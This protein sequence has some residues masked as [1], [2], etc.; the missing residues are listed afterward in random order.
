M[1]DTQRTTATNFLSTKGMLKEILDLRF[2]VSSL[3]EPL[4]S[5]GS[6]ERE[7]AKNATLGIGCRLDYLYDSLAAELERRNE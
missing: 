4:T 3:V 6:Y 1:S 2:S 7:I 5:A